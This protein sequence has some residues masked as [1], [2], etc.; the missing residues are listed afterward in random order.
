MWR[1]EAQ[2]ALRGDKRVAADD[3]DGGRRSAQIRKSIDLRKSAFYL[4]NLR[5]LFSFLKR[6]QEHSNHTGQS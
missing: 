1:G 5:L 3:A 6:L 2:R 4:R